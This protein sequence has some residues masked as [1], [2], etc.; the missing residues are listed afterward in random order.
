MK[1]R[2]D[3][4]SMSIEELEE[5]LSKNKGKNLSKLERE[6]TNKSL[7]TSYYSHK[8]NTESSKV[9]NKLNEK[10]EKIKLDNHVNN[11]ISPLNIFHKNLQN[12]S[13]NYSN[14]VTSSIQYSKFISPKDSNFSGYMSD[15]QDN[16]KHINIINTVVDEDISIKSN[17]SIGINNSLNSCFKC[18]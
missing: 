17:S 11:S 12:E 5:I 14:N 2:K 15:Q 6:D 13:I 8:N 18:S 10:L 7:N 1:F 4:K 3:P 16:F 9:F